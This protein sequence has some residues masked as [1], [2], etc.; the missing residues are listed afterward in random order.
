MQSLLLMGLM[1]FNGTWGLDSKPLVTSA[2][3]RLH[4]KYRHCFHCL[5]A[6]LSSGAGACLRALHACSR[7]EEAAEGPTSSA[8]HGRAADAVTDSGV[9]DT[10]D[11]AAVET[12]IC[13]AARD[14]T[15]SSISAE[16]PFMEVTHSAR[17]CSQCKHSN[18]EFY[19]GIKVQAPD[20]QSLV[21][22]LH[23]LHS[24]VN[25]VQ[26]QDVAKTYSFRYMNQVWHLV[27]QFLLRIQQCEGD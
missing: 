11:V 5:A 4:I 1:G 17:W 6:S 14:I 3:S 24:G 10:V 25:T 15:G 19:W 12:G 13:D 21:Q 26:S 8:Y 16:Q 18:N 20:G 23:V 9:K 2:A 7:L 27:T 22:R